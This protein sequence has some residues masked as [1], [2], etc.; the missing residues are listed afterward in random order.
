M[1]LMVYSSLSASPC[2][3]LDV[4]DAV[5]GLVEPTEVDGAEV[6]GPDAVADLLEGDGV[7]FEQAA[8]EDLSPVPAKGGVSRYPADLEVPRV[9]QGLRVVGEGL[10][11]GSVD[12]RRGLHVERLVGSLVVIDSTELVEPTLLSTEVRP[13]RRSGPLLER[14]VHA[15]MAAVLLRLTR[16]DELGSDAERDPPDR[17]LGESCD[18]RGSEGM[19]VV[20]PDALR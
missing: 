11:G 13:W 8:D 15:F 2:T 4:H 1:H 18:G 5:I 6:D 19:A 9:L 7:L 10:G 16:F 14:S 3:I 12:G 20:R 17:E